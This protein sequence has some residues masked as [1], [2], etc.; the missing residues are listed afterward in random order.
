MLDANGGSFESRNG[1]CQDDSIAQRRAAF[2][3][4][5]VEPMITEAEAIGIPVTEIIASLI[6]RRP[7][8]E[9]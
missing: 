1:N 3:A 5:F 9:E 6:E 4:D 2:Y 8:V 7:P